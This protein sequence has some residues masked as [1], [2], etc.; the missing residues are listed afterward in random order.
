MMLGGLLEDRNEDFSHYIPTDICNEL[1][2]NDE[3]S[4]NK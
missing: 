4:L 3:P 1:G 2:L